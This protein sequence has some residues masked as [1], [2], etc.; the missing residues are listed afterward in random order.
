MKCPYCGKLTNKVV[1]SRLTPNQVSIRRRR[2][3]NTCCERFT[4]Y[5]KVEEIPFMV[6]KKDGRRELFQKEKLIEGILKAVQ[7]RPIPT[8]KV[9]ELTEQ[10]EREVKNKFPKEVPSRQL[11]EQ[12]MKSLRDLDKVAYVR[13]ASV[14]R[15]FTDVKDFLREAGK[16]KGKKKGA[17]KCGK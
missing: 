9:E 11:G 6:V 5:E 10:I 1:D 17:K 16:F 7:K 13:F 15:E 14:Y 12:V 2:E 8:E 3:C 4:T